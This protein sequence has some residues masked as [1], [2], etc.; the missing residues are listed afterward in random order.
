MLHLL[1]DMTCSSWNFLTDFN[2]YG[3]CH[4]LSLLKLLKTLLGFMTSNGCREHSFQFEKLK[5]S[6]SSVGFPRGHIGS[7][8][9]EAKV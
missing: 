9:K 8:M 5:G 1:L 6:R 3:I 2:W 4:Q 7:S